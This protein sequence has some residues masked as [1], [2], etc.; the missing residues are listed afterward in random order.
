MIPTRRWIAS[1]CLVV[2]PMAGQWA[3]ASELSWTFQ[4][5]RP[6]GGSNDH[7]ALGMR[8][9]STWPTAFSSD[10][11]L[12][13]TSLTPAGWA[14]SN[15]GGFS[16]QYMR[17]AAGQDGRVGVVWQ[18]GADVWFAQSSRLGWQATSVGF[19]NGVSGTDSTPS[20]D[21]LSANRP[22][23]GYRDNT[24]LVVQAY[25][26][27]SWNVDR[28]TEVEDPMGGTISNGGNRMSVAVDAIDRVGVAFLDGDVVYAFKDVASSTWYGSR[29][30]IS[31]DYL[32]LAYGPNNETGIAV[33]DNGILNYTYFDTQSGQWQSDLISSVVTSERV[34]LEFNRQGHPALAYVVGDTVQYSIN[35]GGGWATFSLPNGSDPDSGLDV[36]P[37]Q[38]TD[39]A[40]AF[41][42]ADIPVIGYYTY[43][44]LTL[45][46]DPL[47]TPE[48]VS[49]VL[50]LIGAAMLGRRQRRS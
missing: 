9:G 10:N 15:L 42:A 38:Y 23:V 22:V 12:Q 41:D 16:S 5:I 40:L 28:I 46:Y 35:D 2:V 34:N 48:P 50:L 33:L 11:G 4:Q 37:T 45:A 17:S 19:T 43:D 20:V 21:Y 31:G 6:S 49:L 30:G 36:T 44:G 25:D 29:T 27:L 7:V 32:S 18:D 26:G 8:V 1:L 47:V 14:N 3:S 13:A 39:A 24:S